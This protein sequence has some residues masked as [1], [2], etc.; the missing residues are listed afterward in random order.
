MRKHTFILSA[1]AIAVLLCTGLAIPA[2]TADFLY[3]LGLRGEMATIMG[4]DNAKFPL[5]DA[6][7][8]SLGYALS[9]R[10]DLD[11]GLTWYNL[12]DDSSASSNFSFGVNKNN[13]T[14]QFKATRLGV[15]V[16]RYLLTMGGYFNLSV[17]FGG[18]LLLWKMCDP[19]KGTV[20]EVTGRQDDQINFASNEVFISGQVGAE[21]ALSRHLALNLN[22][23]TDYLTGAGKD[24]TDETN[25]T[26]DRWLLGS[27]LTFTFSFGSEDSQRGWPSQKAWS[28]TASKSTDGQATAIDSDG[29]GITDPNDSCGNTPQNVLVDHKGCPADSDR[30]GVFD[31]LDDC[32]GTDPTARGTVDVFGCPVDSDFD[33]IPDYL[34]SC[35]NNAIGAIVDANGCTYDSDSDG[36]P[37]GLD[38]CPATLYGVNVDAHGCIDLTIFSKPMVIDIDY[39]PG[40]FEVDPTNLKRLKELA[41]ILNFVPDIKLDVIGYTDNLGSSRTNKDISEKRA[42]RVRDYLVVMDVAA[43]RISVFGRGESNFIASNQT[44]TGRAKNRRVEIIFYK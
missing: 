28:K 1:I 22:I 40:S 17:G 39:V 42:R 31:G 15:D 20:L 9:E 10:W 37:D 21:F 6:Y 36:I 24:F 12:Y 43:E 25:S 14:R 27:S 8:L 4:G 34:D 29:D 19:T 7:G 3:T 2:H 23:H 16:K 5:R 38:D 32:D 26:R 30:D 13:S 11:L 33:G 18:G 44:E 35:S 41:R